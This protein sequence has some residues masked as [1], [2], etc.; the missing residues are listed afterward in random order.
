MES[1]VIYA[2]GSLILDGVKNY[3]YDSANRLVQVS[4][5]LSVTSLSYNGLGQRL[6]MDAAGVIAH[7]VLDGNQPLTAESNGNTTFYLYGL[8]AIGEETNAW[9]YSLPDG[10]NTPRQLSD[11]SGNITLSARYTP[12]GD[13]LDSFGTGNFTFGYLGGVLDA[14]TGLLYVGNGQYYD[15]ATGRFLTRDVYP[16]SPNP[17]VPWNPLG[18]ILAPLA[19]LSMFYGRKKKRNKWD[20]LIIL[21]LLGASTAIGIVACAPAPTPPSGSANTAPPAMPAQTQTPVPTNPGTIPATPTGTPPAPIE[22]PTAISCPTPTLTPGL[23]LFG[24]KF[25]GGW[26]P[27]QQTIVLV[28]VS[29][30][31]ERFATKL[32]SGL[33]SASAFVQVY[34]SPFIFY[35][36]GSGDICEGGQRKVVCYAQAAITERLLVHELGH[37]LQHSRY[38]DNTLGPY[39][40]LQNAQIVD[41]SGAWV[42]GKHP[43]GEFERSSLGYISEEPPYMYHGPR[44]NGKG[45]P[46][47]NSNLEHEARNEDFAD[48]FMNWTYNSFDYS[49]SANGAGIRRYEWMDSNMLTWITG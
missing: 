32:G 25:E 34:G 41:Y 22:T 1:K 42:T 2:N 37:A 15:P 7:Y 19:V 4:D 26:A 23:E 45:F 29:A 31:G 43:D 8:G 47:W 35:K 48:M 11:L 49:P 38:S 24:I 39:A 20:T 40:S 14:T 5:Q 46:G 3:T 17:Y 18:A 30:V 27:E 9:S 10:T 13:T 44:I 16:N 28:A 12:W 36:A 33:F 21:V 6:S